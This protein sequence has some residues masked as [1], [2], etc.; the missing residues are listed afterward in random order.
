MLMS[1]LRVDCMMLAGDRKKKKQ[2]FFLKNECL[3]HVSK[4]TYPISYLAS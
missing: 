3:I 1:S 2:K 4:N